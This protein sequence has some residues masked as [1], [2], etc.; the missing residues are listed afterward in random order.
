M[1]NNCYMTLIT[2]EKYIPCTIRNA[3]RLKYLKSKYPL[4]AMV[5]KCDLNLK[6]QLEDKG[7]PVA[8]ID[9]DKYIVGD[10]Y[11][12]YADTINKFKI[13]T[14]T[15]YDKI[16]FSHSLGKY[17]SLFFFS[18]TTK[19]GKKLPCSL[20]LSFSINIFFRSSSSLRKATKAQVLK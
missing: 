9:L 4:I 7:V 20:I 17:F 1:E 10:K 6:K 13:L 3:Q 11:L 5:P 14:F 8:L 19:K 18:T 16:C 12:L 15:E 2:Q